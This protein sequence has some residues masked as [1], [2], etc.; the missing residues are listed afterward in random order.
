[1]GNITQ[2]LMDM[3][4]RLSRAK[5]IGAIPIA[6]AIVLSGAVSF[7]Y[8]YLLKE[9]GKAVDH[10]FLVLS[11]IDA[12][13]LRLQDAETGQ[14]GF[15]I[16]GEDAYLAPFF[17]AEDQIVRE[18]S[19]LDGLISDNA[20]Q[21][22]RIATLQGLAS[23]KFHELKDTIETRRA[24]GFESA[25]LFVRSITGEMREKEH[26]LL[27]MRLSHLNWAEGLM[28]LIAAIGVALSLG[29]RFLSR[30]S[31]EIEWTERNS[32][33][34]RVEHG[35]PTLMPKTDDLFLLLCIRSIGLYQP[36]KGR[37]RHRRPVEPISRTARGSFP[38]LVS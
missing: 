14:R 16:T 6:A 11:K 4:A 31:S 3:P 21:S 36:T 18:L 19:D 25:R 26:G 22:T 34:R 37:F 1:M 2:A 30:R 9:S 5:L 35:I 23:A 29:G 13:S 15:I 8:N 38:D 7:G 12:T 10:T 27:D 17:A 24:D 28:L 32:R 20:E 33:L